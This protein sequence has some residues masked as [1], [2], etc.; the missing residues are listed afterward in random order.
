MSLGAIKKK[1]RDSTT[2]HNVR[3]ALQRGWN[4]FHYSRN[5]ELLVTALLR[6]K[7]KKE[8]KKKKKEVCKVR[9]VIYRCL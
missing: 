4:I 1:K 5:V 2:L 8:K 6:S 3:V 7:R 9:A